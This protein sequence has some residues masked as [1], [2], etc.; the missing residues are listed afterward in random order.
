MAGVVLEAVIG[1]GLIGLG[2]VTSNAAWY[3]AAMIFG[4]LN[5]FID[6]WRSM[7]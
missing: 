6:L 2:L 1:F 5:L 4:L 3:T 7:K